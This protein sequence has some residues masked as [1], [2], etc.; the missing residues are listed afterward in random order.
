MYKI[1]YDSTNEVY[2]VGDL[3]SVPAGMAL[4]RQAYS[5]DDCIDIVIPGMGSPIVCT[6][7]SA[8]ANDEAGTTFFT[9]ADDIVN[10]YP[11]LFQTV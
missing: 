8:I 11:G 9:S 7:A 5:N 10:T 1:Y 3:R 6:L 4:L 2:A